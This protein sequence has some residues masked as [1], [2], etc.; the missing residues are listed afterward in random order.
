MIKTKGRDLATV[1]LNHHS[2]PTTKTNQQEEHRARPIITMPRRKASRVPSRAAPTLP[3]DSIIEPNMEAE[4]RREK[5]MLLLADFDHEV[6]SRVT[7]MENEKE[8]IL[9]AIRHVYRTDM[10]RYPLAVRNLPWKEG[11][12][13]EDKK[14]A[15]VRQS[16]AN[17]ITAADNVIQ[18]TVKK[19]GRKPKALL[20][21]EMG[22]ML[23]PPSAGTRSTRSTIQRA[24]LGSSQSDNMLPPP[25]TARV[26]RTRKVGVPA[27]PTGQG[28]PQSFMSS[29]YITPKFDPRTPLPSGTVKRKPKL[30]E[31]AISLTG[32]PLQVSP[33]TNPSIGVD[34][35]LETVDT[36][37]MDEETKTQLLT[38]Q[39]KVSKLLKA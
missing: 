22:D 39:E 8:I 29:L 15:T 6:Q 4:H 11:M 13:E 14:S 3:N 32:S 34:N 30:G 31:I 21:Q 9:Q 36:Q 18:T 10:L 38:I 17:I 27:T 28:I 12:T 1:S 2:N 19:R 26:Q 5:K 16:M 7:M 33:I 37:S 25:S 35:W 23:P 20:L 24:V